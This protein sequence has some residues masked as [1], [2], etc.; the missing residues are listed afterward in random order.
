VCAGEDTGPGSGLLTIGARESGAEDGDGDED[1]GVG[2][3]S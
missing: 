3:P 2:L 1:T